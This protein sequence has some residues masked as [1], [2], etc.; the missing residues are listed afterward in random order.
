MPALFVRE[1]KCRPG[2]YEAVRLFIE[3][4]VKVQPGFVVTNAN[5]PAVRL[6]RVKIAMP[7]GASVVV[8]GNDLGMGEVV[9]LLTSTLQAA[10]KAADQ[11]DVKTFVSMMRDRAKA[12]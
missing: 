3:R 5:A 4:A 7:Q 11:F 12:G 9:E 1:R 8:S 6:S 2:Q 10:R